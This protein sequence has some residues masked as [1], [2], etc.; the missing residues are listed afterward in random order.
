MM[1]DT[2]I[3]NQRVSMCSYNYTAIS[4]EHMLTWASTARQK[5]ARILAYSVSDVKNDVDVG[6]FQMARQ[7]GGQFRI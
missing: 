2:N 5:N 4:Q 1:E 3:G 7:N 6:I